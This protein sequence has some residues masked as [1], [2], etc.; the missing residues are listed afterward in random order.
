MPLVAI[1][2]C[3]K[4]EDY[5]QSVL[6]VGGDVRIIDASI[7]VETAL[8][9]VDGLMLTGGDDVAPS[10]YG[11]VAHPSVVKAEP[12][13]DEFEMGVVREARTRQLPIFAICA[14]LFRIDS[15][16]RPINRTRSPMRCGSIRT[17]CCGG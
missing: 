17:R 16:Y 13:R 7:D 2:S 14:G 3:R 6:H 12:G 5:R 15:P 4:L 10:L 9:G 11:E 1:T 8:A